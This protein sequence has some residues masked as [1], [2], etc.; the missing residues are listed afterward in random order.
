MPADKKKPKR[1]SLVCFLQ[2]RKIKVKGDNGNEGEVRRD[3]EERERER[4]EEDLT[5]LFF[6]KSRIESLAPKTQSR[7]EEIS[8]VIWRR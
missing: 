1:L 3:M 7:R 8:I 5:L 2:E 6:G 4:K